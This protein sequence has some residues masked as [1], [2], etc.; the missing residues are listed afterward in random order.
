MILP[1]LGSE[2]APSRRQRQQ[3]TVHTQILLSTIGIRMIIIIVAITKFETR[4]VDY[5]NQMQK[6]ANLNCSVHRNR[7]NCMINNILYIPN[8]YKNLFLSLCLYAPRLTTSISS[9]NNIWCF[10]LITVN[11][12]VC[13]DICITRDIICQISW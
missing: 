7:Q 13:N 2:L 1:L 8:W 5:I 3:P 4:T 6:Q 11:F 10:K 9:R 12:Y